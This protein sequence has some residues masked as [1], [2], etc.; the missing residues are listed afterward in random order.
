MQCGGPQVLILSQLLEVWQVGTVCYFVA[1]KLF[2]LIH[3]IFIS[4][5]TTGLSLERL[6]HSLG[7]LLNYRSNYHHFF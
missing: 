4:R 1:R 7:L 6:V 5:H 2:N 3:I